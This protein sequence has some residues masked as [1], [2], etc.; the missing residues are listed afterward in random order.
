MK[1]NRTRWSVL[2][3]LV[4]CATAL[5]QA[6]SRSN[7]KTNSFATV[8]ARE[9]LNL[10]A[11]E[12]LN[13]GEEVTGSIPASITANDCVLGATQ[14]KIEIVGG[15]K[16]LRVILGGSSNVDLY[17]RRG[18]PVAVENGAIVADFKSASSNT[19]EGIS[20]PSSGSAPLQSG[21]YFVAITNCATAAADYQL[22]ATITG[23]PDVAVIDLGLRPSTLITG[24][25]PTPVP[26]NCG[27]SRT[28]YKL[29]EG[30]NVCGGGIFWHV[31]IHA[32]QNVNVLIRK[33]RPVTVENGVFMYDRMSDNQVK[34]HNLSN[35]QQTPGSGT[36][37]I[38]VLNCGFEPVNYTLTPIES[39]ADVFP[40][41]IRSV[42]LKKK[43]LYITG[44]FLGGTVLLD[45]QPQTAI[46]GGRDLELG[47]ILII[48]KA[49]KKIPRNQPVIITITRPDGCNSS[50]FAFTRH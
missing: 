38:A 7:Y 43:D 24:S 30:F 45:G 8:A 29:E 37:F 18:A 16:K 10:S 17:I 33:D 28:Q 4:F 47:E 39:V 25:I 50:S 3:I 41:I 42:F 21:S 36:Y 13:S 1:F 5:A 31:T 44:F 19:T 11:I 2:V 22:T 35:F 27:I 9:A 12:P 15:D 40:P 46:D 32:D 6:H 26:G 14:Y 20:I 49:K 48:K 23:P 34:V